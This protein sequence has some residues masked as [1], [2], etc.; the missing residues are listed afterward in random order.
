MTESQCRI[1]GTFCNNAN[2]EFIKQMTEKLFLQ[3]KAYFSRTNEKWTKRWIK[4]RLKNL[5]SDY[6]LLT[7]RFM[8]ILCPY[9]NSPINISNFSKEIEGA[10]NSLFQRVFDEVYECMVGQ[11]GCA[12]D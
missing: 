5:F 6:D 12:A 11:F 9:L 3:A 10:I 7:K 1:C 8:P 2:N 4:D